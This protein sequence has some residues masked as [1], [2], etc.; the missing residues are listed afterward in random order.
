VTTTVAGEVAV[1]D[2]E[3]SMIVDEEAEVV[4]V[5]AS[6]T[7]DV[8]ADVAGAEAAPTVAALEI[9]KA[10]SRLSDKSMMAMPI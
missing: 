8:E 5:V 10:R 7:V 1:E 3:A 6:M 4:V 9:S 2:A